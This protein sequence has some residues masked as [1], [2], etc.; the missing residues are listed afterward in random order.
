MILNG[1]CG[2]VTQVNNQAAGNYFGLEISRRLGFLVGAEA[3]KVLV[4]TPIRKWEKIAG[5]RETLMLPRRVPTPESLQKAWQ[6]IAQSPDNPNAPDAMF[7]RERLLAGEL[8]RLQPERE[9]SL[10]AIQLGSAVLLA[11]PAELFTSL[12]LEKSENNSHFPGHNCLV[13]LANDS[14][15]TSPMPKL[16]IGRARRIRERY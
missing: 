6:D 15:V 4:R 16:S 14:S 13:E 1:P 11:N 9:V 7:A 5:C 10:T 8:A 3:A 2:D 12:A